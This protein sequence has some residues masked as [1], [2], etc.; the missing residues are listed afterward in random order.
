MLSL[1]LLLSGIA[2]AQSKYKNIMISSENDP[3]EV[4]I[5]INPVD[6]NNIVAAANIE[7]YYY[8][9]D[10]GRSW[11]VRKMTSTLGVWGDP[12]IVSDSR[13]NFYYFHL[14]SAYTDGGSWLDRIVCQKSFDGG[15]SWNDGSY[16]GKN[17]PHLQ[18]KEWAA[19]DLTY[20][21]YRDNIYAVWTQCG[22]NKY[23]DDGASVNPI[24][25]ASNIFMSFSSDV[26]ESWST[27]K[28]INEISGADCSLAESTV[29]G[30]MPCV[31]LNGE[32]NVTWSSQ[33]GLMFDRSTDG[34]MTWLDKDITVALMPGG[35]KYSVPGVYRCFGFPSMAC[36]LSEGPNKGTL[37][38][39]WSDQRNGK[40]N[41]D[42]WITSSTNE[43]LSWKEPSKVNDDAGNK[44]QFFS[45][46]TID[47]YS[48]IIF[49]VFYDRRNY[50]DESTDVYL[51]VSTDGG[52][53]FKN[54]VI[55]DSPF[56]PVTSTFMGDYTNI[57]AVRGVIR[58]I[59]T[60]A[61]STKLSVW[62]AIVE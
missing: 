55:S 56:R 36:D 43:G 28:R 42:V 2:F 19:V 45:W 60:R 9:L 41:T 12:C 54:E 46:M 62:T 23:T 8:S 57:S 37:Y 26:G 15:I 31:G 44:H 4:T 49:V 39:S 25:S 3:S 61:D 32:V 7:N 27:A 33:N 20:S 18:D 58:P 16:M 50:D 48:G 40:D 6:L 51:A 13:G 17:P 14:S 22:Q 59:W 53:T 52:N 11:A 35:F 29:L 1:F 38:I 21:P 24:D 10:G 5:S 30:A 34:G 47:S